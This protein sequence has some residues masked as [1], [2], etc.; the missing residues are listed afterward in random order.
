[1]DMRIN[2]SYIVKIQ[3]QLDAVPDK[4]TGSL[5]VSKRRQVDDRLM[6][7]TADVCLEALKFCVSVIQDE[8][9]AVMSVK[10][11]AQNRVVDTLIHKTKTDKPKYPE[12]DLR[13]PNLPAYTRR[14]IIADALG[15][16]KS[17]KSNHK[18]WEQTPPAERGTEPTLGLPSRYE[19]TFYDQERKMSCLADGQIGLKLYNGHTWDW[20]Y[21][22]ISRADAKHIHEL[23]QNRKMLS[24]VVDKVRGRYRIRFAFSESKALV[25]DENRLA[26]RILVYHDR[27]RYCP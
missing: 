18:N 4:K 21:F 23:S 12:F 25:S 2:T 8:W 20:H 3:S 15:M 14:A 5:V 11:K 9:D 1:M 6:R 24:P 16:V 19:L 22:Q 7:C 26:Y 27:R 13:F 17:Y 10:A